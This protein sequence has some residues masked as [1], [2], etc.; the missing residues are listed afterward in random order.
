MVE[1]VAAA[2]AVPT[3]RRTVSGLRAIVDSLVRSPLLPAFDRGTP[4]VSRSVRM[5]GTS[6]GSH[7]VCD[8]VDVIAVSNGLVARKD[9]YLDLVAL[10]NQ[11]GVLP[12]IVAGA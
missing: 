8:G 6:D 4:H 3:I 10:A 1:M 5:S 11:V 2:R 9:T 7:F 12:H